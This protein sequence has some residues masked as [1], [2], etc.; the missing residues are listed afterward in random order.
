MLS[1]SDGE[2]LGTID[3][4]MLSISDGEI[5]GTIDGAMPV[6]SDGLLAEEILI[7]KIT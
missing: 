7:R 1:I 6:V 2:I 5:L 4:A 3:G